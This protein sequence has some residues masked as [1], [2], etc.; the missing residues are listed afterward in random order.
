[1]LESRGETLAR[2]AERRLADRAGNADA[3]EQFL[4][5][6]DPAQP[7]VVAGREGLAGAEARAGVADA[8]LCRLLGLVVPR[9]APGQS[10]YRNEALLDHIVAV[11]QGERILLAERQRL[12][13]GGAEL[14]LILR[15]IDAG[16]DGRLVPDRA[17]AGGGDRRPCRSPG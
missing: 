17:D 10:G 2:R 5:G 4:L 16:L 7:L 6:A 9:R 11:L 12:A 3:A 14:A 15:G 13:H 8:Q 1:M